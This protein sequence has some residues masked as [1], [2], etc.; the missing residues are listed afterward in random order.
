MM[1]NKQSGSPMC[2]KYV[3]ALQST[4]VQFRNTL[5]QIMNVFGNPLLSHVHENR[6]L[7]LRS[8]LKKCNLNSFSQWEMKR[9]LT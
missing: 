5:Q 1:R 3:G 9:T 4:R 2:R 6:L 7:L 8:S